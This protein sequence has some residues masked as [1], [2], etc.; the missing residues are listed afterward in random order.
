MS[1]F[2]R[3]CAA[4]VALT[5]AAGLTLTT[6][7]SAADSGTATATT[8][9][10]VTKKTKTKRARVV[11]TTERCRRNEIRMTWQRYEQVV[12]NSAASSDDTPVIGPQG[13]TG[14]QGPRGATGPAGATGATGPAGAT[15]PRGEK[16]EKGDTGSSGA[17]GPSDIFTTAGTDGIPSTATEDTRATLTLP[18]GSYLLMGQARALSASEVGLWFVRCRIFSAGAPLTEASG[19]I[20]DDED[21]NGDGGDNLSPA[22]RPEVS[23]MFMMTPLT[24]GATTTVTLRCQGI[25]DAPLVNNVQ[26]TAIKTGSLHT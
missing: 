13:L 4:T 9:I 14:E 3:R 24:V 20:V 25:L 6:V 7:A 22:T 1:P 17:A 8:R 15:G 19:S 10:C 16:G 12:S 26:L 23:N 5:V 21:D 18:A 11:R 2:S